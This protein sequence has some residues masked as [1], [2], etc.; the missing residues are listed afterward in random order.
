MHRLS[1]R[2]RRFNQKDGKEVVNQLSRLAEKQKKPVAS[3]VFGDSAKQSEPQTVKIPK[4]PVSEFASISKETDPLLE[5]SV[6]RKYLTNQALTKE[7]VRVFA[8]LGT[9]VLEKISKA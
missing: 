7:E 9:D 4:K 6:V 3:T 8:P 5:E 2:E 1:L